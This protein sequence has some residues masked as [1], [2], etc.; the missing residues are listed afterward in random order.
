MKEKTPYKL[1][2]ICPNPEGATLHKIVES[3]R[4]AKPADLDLAARNLSVARST[5][6]CPA[7]IEHVSRYLL[8][9]FFALAHRTGLYNRQL[10][11][12]ETLSKISHLEVEQLE[13][14]IFTRKPMPA[15]QVSFLDFRQRT[16]ILAAVIAAQNGDARKLAEFALSELL[17]K[18]K[19][20][21]GVT[22]LAVFAPTSMSAILLDKI[23]KATNASDPV[24]KYESKLP[25]P[26]SIPIDLFEFTMGSEGI[27]ETNLI[28]PNL[29]KASKRNAVT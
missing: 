4:T 16:L 19:K 25:A 11:F 7:L 14:G 22:G 15:Y 26:L 28:H 1:T 8:T 23:S 17:F 5:D 9:D 27:P 21:Q 18:A 3:P 12:W 24:A 2:V 6:N 10:T 29:V 13:T 20:T